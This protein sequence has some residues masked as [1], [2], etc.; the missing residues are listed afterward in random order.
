MRG[1]ALV[2]AAV[3]TYGVFS[4]MVAERRREIGIRMALGAGRSR[5]LAQVMTQGLRLTLLGLVLGLAGAYAANQVI[6]S[7]LFAVRPSDPQTMAGV[8]A[9]IV[10]VAALACWLPAFRASRLD[11]NDV[12]RA[13]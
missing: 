6:A 4:F 2:L 9:A 13:D 11:P 8:I 10:A 1:L 12:L 7:M 3:G 5:V